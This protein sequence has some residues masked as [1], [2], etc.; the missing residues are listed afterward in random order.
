MPDESL[1]YL[2]KNGLNR[3]LSKEEIRKDLMHLGWS[4]VEI[5]EGFKAIQPLPEPSLEQEF[6]MKQP[7]EQPSAGDTDFKKQQEPIRPTSLRRVIP[8]ILTFLIIAALIGGFFTYQLKF[9]AKAKTLTFLKNNAALYNSLFNKVTEKADFEVYKVTTTSEVTKQ[10]LNFGNLNKAS[11]EIVRFSKTIQIKGL[12]KEINQFVEDSSNYF[13]LISE[14]AAEEASLLL[15]GETILNF[16]ERFTRIEDEFLYPFFHPSGEEVSKKINEMTEEI[17]ETTEQI[18]NIKIPQ[19]YNL[20]REKII[21]ALNLL[22]KAL[23]EMN[24]IIE[25]GKLPDNK[26]AEKILRNIDTFTILLS[27]GVFTEGVEAD[28]VFIKDYAQK[29][30]EI[31]NLE[32]KLDQSTNTLLTKY[33]ITQYK[34]ITPAEAS[35][36]LNQILEKNLKIKKETFEEDKKE[37]QRDTDND[38]L[39]DL[40]EICWGTFGFIADSDRDGRKD[41][42]EVK[43]GYDPLNP[44]PKIKLK[45]DFKNQCEENQISY[46]L[47]F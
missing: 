41:G 11:N 31:K 37:I 3:G 7:M 15:F 16:S 45:T 14:V 23:I 34:L 40:G 36:S 13:S 6:K 38:G 4:E 22:N 2:I 9:S 26:Q 30:E 29:V 1:I 12:P 19:P 25:T 32:K 35:L 10:Q 47:S 18:K 17:Q 8:F 43:N 21:K 28:N 27:V 44:D 39:S 33:K 42:E 46:T 5:E 20:P 24:N